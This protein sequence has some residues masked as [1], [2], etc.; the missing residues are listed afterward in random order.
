MNYPVN[1]QTLTMTSREIAEAIGK[2]HRMIKRDI[3]NLFD[4]LGMELT[5][6]T[7]SYSDSMNRPQVEY[8]LDIHLV[9][10][11]LSRKDLRLGIEFSK[12][13][14][15]KASELIAVVNAL[16]EFEIPDDLPEMF[17]YYI[18][19][20]ATGNVKI[21]ISQNPEERRKHLQTGCDGEL[22]IVAVKKA[23]N[24][25]KDEKLIHDKFK[26]EKIHGEWFSS[27]AL[28]DVKDAA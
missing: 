23:E 19:N 22:V 14:V 12:K 9:L 25:F 28:L 27:S 24:R 18:Q 21:G 3:R 26:S 2:E 13:H 7:S 11:F 8:T 17:I 15:K 20:V 5:S 10:T 1:D 16:S 4:E 6:C